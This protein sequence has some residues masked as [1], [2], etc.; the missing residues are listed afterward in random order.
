[1]LIL[2]NCL[3]KNSDEGCV[4]VAHNIVKRIKASEKNVRV[5]SYERTSELTD[6]CVKSNKLMLSIPLIKELQKAQKVL[7]IPFP[8]R[9]I[10]TAVR[11]WIVSRFCKDLTVLISM[12]YNIDKLSG[13]LLKSSK[14]KLTVLSEIA[15]KDFSAVA[16]NKVSYIKTGVDTKKFHP[17]DQ[18][19][20]LSLREKYGIEKSA[21]VILHVGHL[22][23]GRN[24][25]Q[26]LN[27]SDEY[28]V[29]LVTSTLTK[30]EQDKQLKEEFLKRKNTLLIDEFVEHIEEI[31]Q[32][33]DLYFFPVVEAGH[34]IDVPL[35]VLEA[36]SCGIPVL[37]TEYGEAKV[38][39]NKEG[40]SYISSFEN[41]DELV[42][43]A[44]NK[45]T[46]K[47][48]DAV[49]DYDWNNAV[50]FLSRELNE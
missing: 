2:T 45:K 6:T 44:I 24:I 50:E 1:M 14:A 17:T 35:S 37:T 10:A 38:F 46:D 26:L 28:F 41:L 25:Q 3:T 13:F 12:H 9:T 47:I 18:S 5:V 49:L 29:I 20:K 16:G 30:N 39:K 15:Y 36:A 27:L 40:F 34:C 7:Y 21:K 42:N 32:L 22:K 43:K 4:N 31:Y 19:T 48:R 8:A 23:E 11:I 33:S